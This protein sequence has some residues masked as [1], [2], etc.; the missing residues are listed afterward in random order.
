MGWTSSNKTTKATVFAELVQEYRDS[1]IKVLDIKLNKNGWIVVEYTDGSVAILCALIDNEQ[2]Y[3]GGYYTKVMDECSYP[4]HYDVPASWLVK[5]PTNNK[6]ANLW[7]QAVLDIIDAK[8][9]I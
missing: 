1:S 6:N 5:Y 7:R 9:A 8:Q 2:G 4:Y 3:G